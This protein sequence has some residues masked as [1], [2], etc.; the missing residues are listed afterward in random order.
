MK[1]VRHGL[2]GAERPGLLDRNGCLRD[3]SGHLDDFA[4]ASLDP[5]RLTEIARLDPDALPLLDSSVRLG[6]CVGGVGKIVCA[7]LNY[8]SLALAADIELPREPV[9]FL[10]AASALS[11]PRDPLVLPPGAAEVDWEVELAVV[12]GRRAQ[13]VAPEEAMDHVAGFCIMND[14]SE[15]TWQFGEGA[16]FNGGQWDKGK[17]HDGFAPLGP[18]LVTRDEI[19]DPHGL[20]LWLSVDGRT[21]Q[22]E[23]TSDMLFPIPALIAWI[24]RYMT[25]QPGDLIATGTPPGSAFLH[26]SRS[27]FLRPGQILRAGIAGLGEQCQAVLAAPLS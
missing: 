21:M 12:M 1:L 10:K 24:S 5:G 19:P 3:L 20:D 6:P 23:N 22:A 25:L 27:D 15:R 26:R 16:G 2:P 14:I 13:R 9:L 8:R 18:W 11:G 7:G 17:N 4:R